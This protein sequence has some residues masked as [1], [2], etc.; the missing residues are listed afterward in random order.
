MSSLE[1]AAERYSQLHENIEYHSPCNKI[2]V[3]QR[4]NYESSNETNKK[5]R[6]GPQTGAGVN[7]QS[8]TKLFFFHKKGK[9]AE[10]SETENYVF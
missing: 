6:T 2:F 7:P 5:L 4:S 9:D 10:C 8:E 3:R 1:R